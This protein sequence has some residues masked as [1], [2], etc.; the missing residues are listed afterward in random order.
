MSLFKRL[1]KS[2]K[3]AYIP[4]ISAALIST[5]YTQEIPEEKYTSERFSKEVE[6]AVQDGKIDT[7]EQWGIFI[8]AQRTIEDNPQRLKEVLEIRG[9]VKKNLFGFDYGVPELEKR[10]KREGIRVK[11][12]PTESMAESVFRVSSPFL[13]LAGV[14]LYLMRPRKMQDLE[15]YA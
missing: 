3:K 9:L 2:V 4:I 15:S 13:F 8:D 10:F 6:S 14:G 5:G 11:V 1:S 12:E 7:S